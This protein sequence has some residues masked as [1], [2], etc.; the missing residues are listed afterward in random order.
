MSPH[1]DLSLAREPLERVP[2]AQVA[3]NI[4]A[5]L[6]AGM[7]RRQA[8]RKWHIAYA[9]VR[10]IAI[11]VGATKSKPTKNG[12]RNWKTLQRR[13]RTCGTITY[14]QVLDLYDA[15]EKIVEI[16]L[17]AGVSSSDVRQVV[18]EAGRYA[19]IARRITSER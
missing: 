7:S 5:D 8:S 2:T 12:P 4:A 1:P 19:R 9:T 15:G 3:A 11:N 18:G 13:A 16:A 6:L 14:G 17:A 10:T